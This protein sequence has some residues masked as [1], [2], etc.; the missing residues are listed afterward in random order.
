MSRDELTTDRV[1]FGGI[2]YHTMI[3]GE[4]VYNLTKHSVEITPKHLGL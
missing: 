4:A 3:I 2:V 1:L